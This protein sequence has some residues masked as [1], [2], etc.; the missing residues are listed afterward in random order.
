MKII[1]E[2][3]IVEHNLNADVCVNGYDHVSDA[4][5]DEE[6]IFHDKDVADKFVINEED[7]RYMCEE[8]VTNNLEIEID[9]V[10][11]ERN[12]KS[13]SIDEMMKGAYDKIRLE[14][15]ASD[16]NLEIKEMKCELDGVVSFKKVLVEKLEEVA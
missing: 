10:K 6:R 15:Y 1:E 7:A 5:C 4:E 12:M 2:I 8:Y 16:H 9:E 13:I 3:L 11:V 14:H